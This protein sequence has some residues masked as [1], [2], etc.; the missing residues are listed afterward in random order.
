MRKG[1]KELNDLTVYPVREDTLLVKRNLEDQGL[2]DT[3]FLEVG[4]GNAE[5]SITAAKNGAAVTAV[6]I[7]PEAVHHA[8][9][10]FEKEGLEA[11]VFR[12]DIFES[13]E[14]EFDFIVFNPPYLS[15]PEGVGDEE[16]WRGGETGLEV[17][18][19]FLEQVPDYLSV[20]GR[21]WVV[22]SDRTGYDEVVER[23]GLSEVDRENLWFE[24]VFLFEF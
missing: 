6:D 8:R 7:D 3:K 16:M 18:E 10:R 1:L 15:G 9:E 11:E 12:S 19:R 13:V 2:D 21:A 4:V 22:L 24:T 20:D 14:G 5:V 17:A 23:F